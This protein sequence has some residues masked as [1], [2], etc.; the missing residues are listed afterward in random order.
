MSSPFA[1]DPG[2]LTEARMLCHVACQWP[3]K[4][5]RA[6]LAAEADDSHSNLGWRSQHAGLLS[7]FLDGGRRYQVG[8]S[9][10]AGALIWLVADEVESRLELRHETEA[11]VKDWVDNRLAQASLNSTDHAVMPYELEYEARYAR[12]AQLEEA[13][14]AL[15]AWYEYG[16]RGL[17]KLVNAS[18]GLSVVPPTVRC[19]PH[20]FDLGALFALEEGDPETARSIG[21]GLSPGDD[22]FDEPYFYCSP[23]PAPDAAVLPSLPEPLFWNREGFVS[24]ILRSSDMDENMDPGQLLNLAFAAAREMT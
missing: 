16:Q 3:S 23:Y 14:S 10:S 11:S 13:V 4:A 1:V 9:F 8:F 15:G 21:V 19:W 12:L 18:R 24:V 6:N 5:A 17:E 2:T 22:S 20:H 7:R